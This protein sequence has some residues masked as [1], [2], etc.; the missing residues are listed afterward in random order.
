MIVPRVGVTLPSFRDDADTALAAARRAEAAG[1]DGVFVFDHLWPAGQPERPA[2]SAAPLLGALAAVTDSVA[3]GPLVARVGLV[4]DAVLVAGLVSLKRL[5]KGRLIAG[6]GTGDRLSEPEN[7]AYGIAYP[8]AA[9]RRA[10]LEWCARRLG[11]EAVPTW[12]GG[13]S[14]R[15]REVALSTGAAVNLWGASPEEVA[16]VS[17]HGEVTWGGPVEGDADAIATALATL[18]DAGATWAVCAWPSSLEDVAEAARHLRSGAAVD[19]GR[20]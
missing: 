17:R 10:S 11:E 12:V 18:F 8:P 5:S 20:I 3:I 13:G 16:E 4:P 15:T 1:L 6:L 19:P 7:A 2:L 14:A 9:E